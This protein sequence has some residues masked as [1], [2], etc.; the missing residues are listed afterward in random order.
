MPP[1]PPPRAPRL[2]GRSGAPRRSA[3]EDA[4]GRR[5]LGLGLRLTDLLLSLLLLLLPPLLLTR[6]ALLPLRPLRLPGSQTLLRLPLPHCAGVPRS[7]RP[8]L[9]TSS[10]RE[11]RAAGARSE[12]VLGALPRRSSL[13]PAPPS[14]PPPRAAT[15]S[16][17]KAQANPRRSRR[18]RRGSR[19]LPACASGR[20]RGVRGCPAGLSAAGPGP[21][22]PLLLLLA[23]AVPEAAAAA[24]RALA[25]GLAVAARSRTL[26][27]CAPR[28]SAAPFCPRAAR[29][30][31]SRD[32]GT[33]LCV[34][35]AGSGRSGS[36]IQ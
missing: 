24:A 14:R 23:V 33:P 1:P 16:R 10:S 7:L 3:R 8:P 18:P 36:L 26:S 11:A 35:A 6:R 12:P 4:A 25:A 30:S 21:A 15:P 32:L 27:S 19:R 34:C 29:L 2:P 28:R 17:Q 20:R 31:C 22:P 5:L 9:P 13:S